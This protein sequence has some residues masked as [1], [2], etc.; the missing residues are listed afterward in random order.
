MS[1]FKDFIYEEEGMGTIEIAILIAALVALAIIF[2]KQ[3]SSL[4]NSAADAMTKQ[5]D[6]MGAENAFEVKQ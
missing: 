1:V 3:L 4:W 2:R 5:K 6:D